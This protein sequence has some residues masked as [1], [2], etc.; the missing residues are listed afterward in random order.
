MKLLIWFHDV[1]R[2]MPLLF[3]ALSIDLFLD[4]FVPDSGLFINHVTKKNI[5]RRLCIFNET[6]CAGILCIVYVILVKC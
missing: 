5:Y 6:N 4:Q 3:S 2:K 1:T